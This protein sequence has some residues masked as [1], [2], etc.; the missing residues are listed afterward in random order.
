MTKRWR[1]DFR[2]HSMA[3]RKRSAQEAIE[4]PRIRGHRYDPEPQAAPVYDVDVGRR[5][6]MHFLSFHDLCSFQV[7]GPLLSEGCRTAPLKSSCLPAAHSGIAT[8]RRAA[9]RREGHASAAVA[10][11]SRRARCQPPSAKHAFGDADTGGDEP[12]CGLRALHEEHL[13]LQ[14]SREGVPPMASGLRPETPAPLLPRLRHGRARI[15]MFPSRASVR[16]LVAAAGRYWVS[17]TSSSSAPSAIPTETAPC[18]S[19]SKCRTP[20]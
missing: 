8:Q 16:R 18:K 5:R 2:F 6:P 7:L 17:A 3:N 11:R 12:D 19:G 1:Y 14:R 4:R 10:A 20:R 15:G 13:A 9:P